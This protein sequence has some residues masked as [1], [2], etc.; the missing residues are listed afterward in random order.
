MTTE[1]RRDDTA[2]ADRRRRIRRLTLRL[3]LFAVA[4][5]I[6]FIIAFVNRGP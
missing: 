4:V 5:Y 3:A 6:V 1:A 2:E